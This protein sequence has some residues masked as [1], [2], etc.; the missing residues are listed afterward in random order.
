MISK[1]RRGRFYRAA[2]QRAGVRRRYLRQHDAQ[3]VG[4]L[5]QTHA[6]LSR[7]KEDGGRHRTTTRERTGKEVTQADSNEVQDA[8]DR[9]RRRDLHLKTTF[10]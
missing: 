2:R 6:R 1:P 5:R 7:K 10:E 3:S 4:R 9:F 8:E